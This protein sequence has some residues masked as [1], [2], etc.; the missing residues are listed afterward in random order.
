MLSSI[1]CSVGLCRSQYRAPFVTHKEE[2]LWV[3]SHT[4]EVDLGYVRSLGNFF[5]MNSRRTCWFSHFSPLLEV[6]VSF[7]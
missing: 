7:I 3:N 1:T 6:G 4:V 5:F 2:S